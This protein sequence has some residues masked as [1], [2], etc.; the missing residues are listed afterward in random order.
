MR[1][2]E[3]SGGE[4]RILPCNPAPRDL[5]A[6]KRG[7]RSILAAL[8]S[9][10]VAASI[11]VVGGAVPAAAD[12][13][14]GPNVPVTVTAD[15]LPT[16][17][18]NGVGWTQ[19]I[20]GN[21]VYVGGNF[22]Q[23]RPSGAAPGTQEVPRNH[24]LAYD[25][26]TGVLDTAF[27]PSMNGE[28]TALAASPDGT[29]LYV[30]GSFTAING[31]T[32]WR[33]AALN[34]NNGSIITTFLPRMS[35]SV[36]AIVATP[37]TVYMGGLFNAVGTV[38]RDRLAAVSA[39]N[40]ALLPW[41][42]VA[43]GGRVNALSLSPDGGSMVVGGAFTTLNGSSNP[44][45][46]LGKVD[47]NI[48]A[49]LP[50]QI[51]NVVRNGGTN[52]SIT[53]LATDG[54][55]VY[56]AGYTFGRS[57]TLEGTFSV[58]WAN[59][60]TNW[61]EDCH[62]D[63]YSVFPVDDLV[64]TAGHAHYCGNVGGFPQAEPWEFQ[65]G[66]AF[67]KAASGVVTQESHGYTNFAGTPAPKLQN[68]FPFMNAG[69][70]TGQDQGPWTVTGNSNYIVM[71]GEFTN[72]NSQSQQG[73]VR[74]AKSN[75]APNL[76]GP[77]VTG[78]NFVPTLSTPAPG[79][80]RVRW[81]ANWDPDN[82]NLVYE[83]RRDNILIHTISQAST[84]WNRPG[85]TFVD[86]GRIA[87]RSYAYRLYARDPFG[88]Q[89]VSDIARITAVGEVTPPGTYAQS[90]LADQPNNYWRLGESSGTTG[91]DLAGKD[92]LLLRPGVSLGA[93]G[94]IGGVTDT[95]ANF[96]GTLDGV[97]ADPTLNFR[98]N[99]FSTEAWIRTNTTAGG[100][101]IGYGNTQTA[102]S[103][104]YDRHVYM[105]NLGRIFFGV[106]PGGSIGIRT[107]INSTAPY[108]DNQWHHIVATL[109]PNGMQLFVDGVLAANRTD[110]T[111]AWP[112]DGYWRIGGD[113]LSNWPS[114]PT[115]RFLNG[116]IDEVAIYPT[117]LP[118]SRIQAHYVASG[119]NVN[120]PPA[121]PV[122]EFT[123]STQGL[124]ASVDGT[125]SSDANGPISNYAW[126]FGDGGTGSG[127]TAQHSYAASG[128]YDVTLTVTDNTGFTNSVTH[129]VTVTAPPANQVPVADFSSQVNNLAVAF[130]GS[131]SADADGTIANY[132]WD[133]GDSTTGSGPTV[134]HTYATAG[135]YAVTLTVTDDDGA[136]GIVTKNVSVTAPPANAILAADVFG[137]TLASSWGNADTGGAWSTT[138]TAANYGVGNG[139]GTMILGAP[140]I[141]RSAS[142]GGVTA[143]AADIQVKASMDKIG[144]GGGTFI[145]VTGRRVGADDYRTKLKVSATGATTLYLTRIQGGVET[146][147]TTTAVS[148]L[149]LAAGEPVHL[150]MQVTG[151]GTTTLRAKVWR[152]GTVEPATWLL[153]AT[154]NAA[155]L[156]AAGTTGVL[157]YLS[158]S[159][160]NSPVTVRFD[161]YVVK[162]P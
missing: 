111:S 96:N 136:T 77:R 108:N 81:Q 58:N 132:A 42:P 55:N 17:Q 92:D 129:P 154:D 19:V 118:T 88:V 14:P 140:G 35:A 56:G 61:I 95:A 86:T 47:T 91:V 107:T 48:G 60:S 10:V 78:A 119:R 74:Y 22:S 16:V 141:T 38:S 31:A 76:R 158:G 41:N 112:F 162:V 97:A 29:R 37:T 137:R 66:V 121:P 8:L 45:F 102:S 94:A 161:D 72:V 133:F 67:S 43:A 147:L 153:T 100:K 5:H 3:Q 69:T 138:G 75:I 83:V 131:A 160:T 54:T 11:G 71:A 85:M 103:A 30:G 109:G 151:S 40:G 142:L 33:V 13:A 15:R 57:S 62:G 53:T 12:S 157:G 135:T 27:A 65:R 64:Y 150:R 44:G 134:D 101:I 116:Q 139:V 23:A 28:V 127:V 110:T 122:A 143:A 51:N 63:T 124:T 152:D 125:A 84:F 32:V 149:V 144:N 59:D 46:G 145:S 146:I 2:N 156:Q 148:G 1:V 4:N 70:F 130:N 114:R 73:M 34:P 50:F 126:T 52:G 115:S 159:A 117:V 106:R 68:W 82:E 105:D 93:D 36:R 104:D 79:A 98:P 80:V 89:A 21:K 123:S 39:S 25:I 120:A 9:V 113:N 20:I 87:G 128:T 24:I 155:S 26:T 6:K 49:L 18:H 90:V 7:M 99:T